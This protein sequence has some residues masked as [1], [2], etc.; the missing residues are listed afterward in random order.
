MKELKIA[1]IKISQNENGLWSA[2][3]LHKA[4]GGL[5]KDKPVHFLGNARTQRFVEIL[6]V[7]NP[8]FIETNY[9]AGGGTFMCKE[10]LIQYASWLSPEIDLEVTRAF[11][12]DKEE[13]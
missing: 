4:S 9:G 10:L 1:G 2:N 11:I 12:L 7:E 5:D 13:K 3:D 6:K 8:T